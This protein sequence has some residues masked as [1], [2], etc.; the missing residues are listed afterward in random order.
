MLFTIK[1]Y[2]LELVENDIDTLILGCTHYP[3]LAEAISSVIGNSIE[4]IDSGYETAI[5]AQKVLKEENLL[6][7]SAE[8]GT[9]AFYVSD[10]PDDFENIAGLFL[11]KDMEHTVT[12]I[13]IEKY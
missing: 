2:L 1:R 4:L 6:N 7:N 11:G 13:N 10:T 12:Q 3:L 5:Y 9:S 8:K